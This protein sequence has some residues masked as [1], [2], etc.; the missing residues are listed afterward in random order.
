[1]VL[2][3]D[4]HIPPRAQQRFVTIPSVAKQ[5]LNKYH[6]RNIFHLFKINFR[7]KVTDKRLPYG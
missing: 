7:K 6:V 4:L 3:A 1:M 2:N 5:F